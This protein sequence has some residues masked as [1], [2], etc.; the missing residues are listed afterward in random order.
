MWVVQ[1]RIAVAANRPK[2]ASDS[3]LHSDDVSNETMRQV[4]RSAL[5]LHTPAQMFALVADIE[6]YPD[7]VPWVASAQVLERSGQLVVARLEM[8][9]A[10][11][12][13]TFTTRNVLDEPFRMDLTLVDGPFEMLEGR[14]TFQPL[15]Q[16]GEQP[17]EQLGEQRGTQIGLTIRFAFSNPVTALLLSRTFEKS[18]GEWVDA[19][20]RRARLLYSTA[21]QTAE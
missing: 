6:R 2:A 7:F 11:M 13:E 20:V 3:L 16:P 19:F 9:R 10:G 17:G 12:H 15:T 4:T 1:P 18:C 14:W 21:Q 5:V 8:D